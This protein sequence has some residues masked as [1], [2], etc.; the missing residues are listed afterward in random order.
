MS[1]WA[2]LDPV[3]S[4]AVAPPL[5]EPQEEKYPFW[6]YADAGML[7]VLALLCLVAAFVPVGVLTVVWGGQP[8]VRTMALL[9]AQFLFYG[10]WF[11]CLFGLLKLRYGR[12]FWKSLAWTRSAVTVPRAAAIGLLAAAGTLGLGVL[13][14]A[15][16]VDSM[17]IKELLRDRAS[18]ILVSVFAV[19]LG[20]LCEELAFRGFLLPLLVRSLGVLPGL[21]ATAIPFSVLHGP[22]YSWA[23]QHLVIISLVGVAFGWMRLRSGS[24]LAAAVMHASYN[25]FFTILLLLG[26]TG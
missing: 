14:H 8:P 21:V 22:Q 10:M 3:P 13:L 24:T 26:K 9:F 18:V 5:P 4:E 17:P 1:D 6:G 19:T 15:P 23:W 7:L 16:P 25:F 2:P 12:P 11:L 20:P